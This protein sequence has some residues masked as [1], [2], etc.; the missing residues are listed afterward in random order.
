MV[1]ALRELPSIV[2]STRAGPVGRAYFFS[3]STFLYE[4]HWTGLQHGSNIDFL[5]AALPIPLT[6]L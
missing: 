3:V 5:P 6:D 4:F 2:N 1:S